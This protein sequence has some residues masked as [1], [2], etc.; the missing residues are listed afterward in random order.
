MSIRDSKRIRNARGPVAQ[1]GA[2]TMRGEIETQD[3]MGHTMM[4][5]GV[6]IALVVALMYYAM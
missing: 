2:N 5:I 1:G 6:M 4:W 3:T